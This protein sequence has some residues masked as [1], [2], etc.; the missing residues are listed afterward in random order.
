[1]P[2]TRSPA[3]HFP[4]SSLPFRPSAGYPIGEVVEPGGELSIDY[5]LLPRLP[6]PMPGQVSAQGRR[7]ASR[8]GVVGR[9]D[10]VMSSRGSPSISHCPPLHTRPVRHRHARCAQ[11]SLS[12]FYEDDHA[13]Y[14]ST[15]FN[16]T[17][18][19]TK[20]ACEGGLL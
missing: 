5:R 9:L 4:S 1:M 15:F 19:F 7:R 12:V 20:G 13:F 10:P 6:E 18:T 14:S 8:S 16:E 2:T 17:V 3:A 11:L